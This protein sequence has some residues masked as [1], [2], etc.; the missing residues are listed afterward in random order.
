M[1]ASSLQHYWRLYQ[2]PIRPRDHESERLEISCGVPQGSIIG[3]QLFM[4]YV[5]DMCNVSKLLKYILF[6]DD[7]NIFYSHDNLTELVMHG[8]R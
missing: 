5:N 8:I 4:L 1:K 2:A 7:A 6:A 3:P